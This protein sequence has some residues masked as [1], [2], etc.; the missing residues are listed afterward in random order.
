MVSRVSTT[1]DP[2]PPVDF[3]K[4]IANADCFSGNFIVTMKKIRRMVRMSINEMTVTTG[5]TRRL[6][7]NFT[8][9]ED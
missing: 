2:S 7:W 1:A 4:L 5:A 6:V 9:D 8:D 3:G